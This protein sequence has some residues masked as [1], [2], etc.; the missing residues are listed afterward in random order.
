MGR[1][2]RPTIERLLAGSSMS[3][4]VEPG[5]VAA[6]RSV[7]ARAARRSAARRRRRAVGGV[8]AV[9]AAA[10]VVA[11][12]AVPRLGDDATVDVAT[13]GPDGAADGEG[14]P[15]PV[16]LALR[17]L[18]ALEPALRL[19][20]LATG[21][22]TEVP[23]PDDWADHIS[24]VFFD[25]GRFGFWHGDG[26]IHVRRIDDPGGP[27]TE[28]SLTDPLDRRL[29]LAPSV[30]VAPAGDVAWLVQGGVSCCGADQRP[31]RIELVDLDTGESLLRAEVDDRVVPVGGTE[32]ELY[33]NLWRAGAEVNSRPSEVAVF[34]RATGSLDVLGFGQGVAGH[35]G[36]VL[37]LDTMT[38]TLAILRDGST[39]TIPAP[40]RGTWSQVEGLI[41]I[42][43]SSL[44]VVD[45][46]GR[47]LVGLLFGVRDHE[48]ERSQLLAVDLG[49][50]ETEVLAE[51]SGVNAAAS[52]AADGTVVVADEGRVGIVD[53]GDGDVDWRADT[54][55][56]YFVVG[57][58]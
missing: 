46:R 34:D 30:S 4:A 54:A 37:S 41:P 13:Q 43:A 35:D 18:P 8:L 15:A 49:T 57:A 27:G 47:V 36:A 26:P 10:F 6:A 33:L 50:G 31:S 20:D 3:E 48:A 24:G 45:E 58:G 14:A 40:E 55:D 5:E 32:G 51:L 53:P 25:D 56:G 9:V 42:S 39:T 19:V 23:L 29:G 17:P 7:L 52:W 28:I 1:S 12:V 16:V 22:V 21:E 2:E 11:M 44:G 38:N